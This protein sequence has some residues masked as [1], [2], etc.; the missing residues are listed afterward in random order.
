MKSAIKKVFWFYTILFLILI[1][2]LV[3]LCLFDSN[4]FVANSFNPRLT[5]GLPDVKR[6]AILDINGKA[7]A[8]DEANSDGSYTRKYD[9]TGNYAHVVG[10]TVKGKAGIES[11]YNFRLQTVSNELLQRIG[12]VFLGKEIQ[13]NNV[14][15]TID[16]RL[17]QVAAEALGHEKGSIVA[18]E[19]STGKILAMVSYPTFDSNTVSENWAELN[20]DDENSPLLNRARVFILQVLHLKL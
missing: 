19:P 5:Q 11:K 8:Q 14:V 16:D 1:G 12:H 7:I 4:G 2:Y 13:G 17:Q 3:K 6:G 10:Y 9:E 15:L 20:S 18:I